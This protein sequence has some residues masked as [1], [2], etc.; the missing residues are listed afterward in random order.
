M[1]LI[2]FMPKE[3]YHNKLQCYDPS[4]D[5]VSHFAFRVLSFQYKEIKDGICGS[6]NILNHFASL[7]K[8][9]YILA[10]P[11]RV[12]I[13]VPNLLAIK[14][15]WNIEIEKFDPDYH[16]KVEEWPLYDVVQSERGTYYDSIPKT[17]VLEGKLSEEERYVLWKE[18]NINGEGLHSR[19]LR[20][21]PIC[22][23]LRTCVYI[24]GG[25]KDE[26]GRCIT[27]QTDSALLSCDAYDI[28]KNNYYET[29]YCLPYKLP[30]SFQICKVATNKDETITI[31]LIMAIWTEGQRHPKILL[32][33]EAGGFEEA[34]DYDS[35]LDSVHTDFLIMVI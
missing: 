19:H 26:Q 10:Q 9:S 12:M 23:M 30:P 17:T 29:K 8:A 3:I 33:S 35:I 15:L 32:F 22:F 27:G 11:N 20:I 28:R 2:Q 4:K 13:I 25:L 14:E 7:P 1:Q 16:S 6:N 21:S 34:S 24:G 18:V 5:D 31:I